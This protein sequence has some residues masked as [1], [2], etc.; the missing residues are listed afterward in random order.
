MQAEERVFGGLYKEQERSMFQP[1]GQIKLLDLD[2][3]IFSHF[4]IQLIEVF[5]KR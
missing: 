2:K 1:H 3:P 5:R 4:Q